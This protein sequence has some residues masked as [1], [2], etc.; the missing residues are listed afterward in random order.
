ML[1]YFLL[2]Y[3]VYLQNEQFITIC[4]NSPAKHS[5]GWK[6]EIDSVKTIQNYWE[7]SFIYI[8]LVQYFVKYVWSF[9]NNFFITVLC[10]N[11]FLKFIIFIDFKWIIITWNIK[12]CIKKIW[13]RVFSLIFSFRNVWL[14]KL[15]LFSLL[16]Q[17]RHGS[18]LF[19]FF[20]EFID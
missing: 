17:T 15:L 12:R 14:I 10:Y 16:E 6:I 3:T 19:V 2:I 8:Y 9:P 4:K 11:L 18:A 13:F 1:K 5:T 7:W 20:Y